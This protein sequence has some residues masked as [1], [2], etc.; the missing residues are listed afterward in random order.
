MITNRRSQASAETVQLPAVG[1][2]DTVGSMSGSGDSRCPRFGLRAL[3]LPVV[4]VATIILSVLVYRHTTGVDGPWYAHYGWHRAPAVRIYPLMALCAVPLLAGIALFDRRHK[5]LVPLA[6]AMI[7][8]AG[9]MLTSVLHLGNGTSWTPMIG[10]IESPMALSYFADAAALVN[11]GAGVRDWLTHW[12]ELLGEMYLHSQTKPPGPVLLFTIFVKL[13]G[14]TDRAAMIAGLVIASVI[15]FA[16]P[17]TY[18]L[19]RVLD[20]TRS[21]AFHAAACLALFPSMS[22]FFPLLDAMYVIG[23]CVLIGTWSIA[24]ARNSTRAAIA[25]G[26]MLA[27]LTFFVY[28]V[29]VIGVLLAAYGWILAPPGKRLGRIASHAAVA[30]ATLLLLYVALWVATGFD[31]VANFSAA[32]R[33]QG[34]LLAGFERPYPATIL[35]DLSDFSLGVGWIAVAPALFYLIDRAGPQTGPPRVLLVA[36]LLQLIMAAVTGLLPGETARVWA[37]LTPLVA[38]PAG[39]EL[40]RWGRTSRLTAYFCMLVIL[41]VLAQNLHEVYGRT[42]PLVGQTRPTTR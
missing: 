21:A 22:L 2:T 19:A 10:L 16:I 4:I 41:T 34:H 13:L 35:F 11:G 12:P 25:F 29:L 14:E 5:P 9:F 31:P 18:W 28:N 26:A 15:P 42:A 17:T 27:L 20:A 33:S 7:S 36:G 1:P 32:L 24:V 23:S 30:L 40:A 3:K 6:L 39:A 8:L 38:L 37:F